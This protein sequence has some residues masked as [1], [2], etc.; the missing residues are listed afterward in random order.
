VALAAA[1]QNE[2][3]DPTLRSSRLATHLHEGMT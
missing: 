1:V 2:F 3:N